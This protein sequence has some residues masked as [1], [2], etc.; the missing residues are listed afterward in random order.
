MGAGARLPVARLR[1][2]DRRRRFRGSGW[3]IR[4]GRAADRRDRRRFAAGRSGRDR[5]GTRRTGDQPAH[6]RRR[7]PGH[8]RDV[9]RP[10]GHRDR[11][12]VR[13][14]PGQR[15]P[16]R[17]PT[18]PDTQ[19]RLGCRER[20]VR[21]R[22][23]DARAGDQPAHRPRSAPLRRHRHLPAVRGGRPDP[24][25]WR[26]PPVAGH[27]VQ[28]FRP[29]TEGAF[30]RIERWTRDSD[31][32]VH[33]RTLSGSNLL[34]VYG[35]D[36]GSRI[37]LGGRVHTWLLCETRDDRGNAVSYTYKAEDAAGLDLDRPHER[38]RADRNVNRYLK[39]VRY[40]NT[41]PLLDPDGRRPVDLTPAQIADA[42]WL[43]EVVLDYGEHHPDTP[44][45][46]DT[47]DWPCRPDPFSTYRAGFEVRTYRLCRRILM[48]HHFPDEP[49]VGANCL[50]RAIELGYATGPVAVDTGRGDPARLRAGRRRRAHQRRDCRR[51]TFEY[52]T[53]DRRS[54]GPG[55]GA[56]QPGEPAR[57]RGRA[58]RAVGG[59]GRRGAR[60]GADRARGLPSTT[61]RTSVPAGSARSPRCPTV[62]SRPT[63]PADA[64]NWSTWTATG[65]S[66]WSSSAPYRPVSS[67]APTTAAGPASS[68]SASCPPLDWASPD[69]LLLDLTGDGR[70]DLLIAGDDSAGLARVAGRGRVRP[71]AAR[72]L[73]RRR[74][75]GPRLLLSDDRQSDLPRRHV[76]RRADRPG[77]GPQRRRLLLA[78][79]RLRTL[80]RHGRD[81][82]RAVVR[83]GRT[84]RPG[85]GAPR[86]RR[87]LRARPTCLPGRGRDPA[88]VQPVRQRLV[89]PRRAARPAARRRP[90]RP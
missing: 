10:P 27:T 78:Q 73:A 71:G 69:L 20:P 60:R 50:V 2:S 33:W 74:G 9:R 72:A 56:R 32:D 31:G 85:P 45:P 46:V 22:L 75:P 30:A 24:G 64:N 68:R 25:A 58:D 37:G 29:R 87:R 81:G 21:P 14:H 19:L 4:T 26:A 54:D 89:G 66:S 52:S 51:W 28:R 49:E 84:V 23:A 83:P 15:R 1:R 62:P 86:R 11:R 39:S 65:G 48:F 63:W 38:H 6:R 43:F 55:T 90:D 82:R 44:L 34:A 36:G 88:L 18:R 57:R 17:V 35:R 47:G 7:D 40:G 76:R 59:P 53:G 13:S 67:A 70:A 61:G 41:V 8:R 3:G 12:H 77:P 80:R 79:P 5:A 42:G 16:V